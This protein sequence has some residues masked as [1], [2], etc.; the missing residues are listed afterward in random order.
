MTTLSDNQLQLIVKALGWR[1][2]YLK[3]YPDLGEEHEATELGSLIES[4]GFVTYSDAES[5][6]ISVIRLKRQG[7]PDKL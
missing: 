2:E 4:L 6:E 7:S 1:L 3:E 5:G